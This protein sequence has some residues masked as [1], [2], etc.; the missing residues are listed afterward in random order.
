MKNIDVKVEGTILHLIVDLEGEAGKSARGT[1]LVA[2]SDGWSKIA[3]I[4]NEEIRMSPLYFVK[5]KPRK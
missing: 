1:P 4:G 3:D 2:R 5:A